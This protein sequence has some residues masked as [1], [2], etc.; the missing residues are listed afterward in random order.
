MTIFDLKFTKRLL[1]IYLLNF[2]YLIINLI[3]N[4]INTYPQFEALEN[5][6]RLDKLRLIC[7]IIHRVILGNVGLY[8]LNS[9]RLTTLL[10]WVLLIPFFVFTLLGWFMHKYTKLSYSFIHTFLFIYNSY[11]CL[12]Y[13]CAYAWT[14][15]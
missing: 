12:V 7:Y 11:T 13:L 14:W 10:M 6:Y 4:Q 9:T 8:L 5:T 2:E 3:I 15:T 1:F